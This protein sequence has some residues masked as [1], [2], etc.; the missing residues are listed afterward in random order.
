[1]N[2]SIRDNITFKGCYLLVILQVV[3]ILS[4]VVLDIAVPQWRIYSS[5]TS[6]TMYLLISVYILVGYIKYSFIVN[7]KKFRKIIYFILLL[8]FANFI[9]ARILHP[10]TKCSYPACLTLGSSDLSLLL[11]FYG[12]GTI[13]NEER[14]FFTKLSKL[15]LYMFGIKVIH[16][17]YFFATDYAVGSFPSGIISFPLFITAAIVT[18]LFISWEFKLFKHLSMK[19]ELSPATQ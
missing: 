16:T 17:I 12:F 2:A 15:N 7:E 19:Y 11:L 5:A 13:K 10:G 6:G 4:F 8:L 14:A 9:L 18:I 1:M 3:L